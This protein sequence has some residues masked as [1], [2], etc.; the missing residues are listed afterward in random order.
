ML[1]TKVNGLSTYIG[2]RTSLEFLAS[3]LH[4]VF[5]YLGVEKRQYLYIKKD[6]SIS[7]V[8]VI[9]DSVVISVNKNTLRITETTYQINNGILNP[10]DKTLCLVNLVL[11]FI[12]SAYKDNL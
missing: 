8:Q 4:N 12:R 11:N 6:L 1:F 2:E 9:K 7:V 3:T 10:Y 5:L